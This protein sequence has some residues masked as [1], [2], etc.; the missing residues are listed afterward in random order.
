M[1]RTSV[2]PITLRHLKYGKLD[3]GTAYTVDDVTITDTD[4]S[5]GDIIYSSVRLAKT[6]FEDNPD[7]DWLSCT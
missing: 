3:S 4:V 7:V 2:N 5:I 6:L 1:F